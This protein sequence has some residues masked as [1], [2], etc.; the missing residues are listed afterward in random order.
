MI[1]LAMWLSNESFEY[2]TMILLRTNQFSE[3]CML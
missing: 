2:D 1:C 3:S